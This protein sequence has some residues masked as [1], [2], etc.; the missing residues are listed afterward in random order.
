[1]LTS[2]AYARSGVR[3]RFPGGRVPWWQELKL[4][5][6]VLNTL[7]RIQA[8][9]ECWFA[10]RQR[11]VGA[12]SGSPSAGRCTVV[13]HPAHSE[14]NTP[15]QSVATFTIRS[16]CQA[17]RACLSTSLKR[18]GSTELVRVHAVGELRG[19]GAAGE[20]DP[21]GGGPRRRRLAAGVVR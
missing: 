21:A 17:A 6:E 13:S 15:R 5:H 10:S 9:S 11:C 2:W 19:D 4:A 18:P 20:R 3:F 16:K 8:K 1:M 12:A 14:S 7:S